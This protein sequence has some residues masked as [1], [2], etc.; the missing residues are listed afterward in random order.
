MPEA[1][2]T[3]ALTS[4]FIGTLL[5]GIAVLRVHMRVRKEHGIDDRVLKAIKR[6]QWLTKLGLLLI[7]IGFILSFV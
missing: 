3:L 7:I 5:I 6:E 2:Y 4:E 1:I